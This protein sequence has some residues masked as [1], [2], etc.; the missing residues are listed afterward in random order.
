MAFNCT[1][2][3]QLVPTPEVLS[4]QLNLNFKWYV[5]LNRHCKKRWVDY[6]RRKP[7]L[8]GSVGWMIGVLVVFSTRWKLR[9]S[10]IVISMSTSWN[11]RICT[12]KCL[13]IF[14]ISVTIYRTNW[15]PLKVALTLPSS[16]H[17]LPVS[18][19]R[20][21]EVHLICCIRVEK[22]IYTLALGNL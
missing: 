22:G 17:V 3:K 14:T 7:S 12:I 9:R 19:W 15:L 10:Q 11:A 2:L 21:I 4:V 20:R 8:R 1:Q 6:S 5:N 16:F 18:A 13:L